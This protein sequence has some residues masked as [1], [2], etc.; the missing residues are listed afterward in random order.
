[1]LLTQRNPLGVCVLLVLGWIASS[2]GTIEPIEAEYLKK[3]AIDS[4]HAELV[5]PILAVLRARD[6]DAIQLAC[7]ATAETN[8]FVTNDARLSRKVVSG[9]D[10]IVPLDQ[11]FL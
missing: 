9:V 6:M 2:D 3:I 5:G 11:V 1:M 4:G 10:F 7:A 8:L